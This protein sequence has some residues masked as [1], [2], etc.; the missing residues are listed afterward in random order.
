MQW[1]MKMKVFTFLIF[2][3]LLI[4]SVYALNVNF[5]NFYT[6]ASVTEMSPYF[7]GT[8]E[9]FNESHYV[10]IIDY[11]NYSMEEKADLTTSTI[12]KTTVSNAYPEGIPL[13]KE[14]SIQYKCEVYD[15]KTSTCTKYSTSKDF[16]TLTTKYAVIDNTWIPIPKIVG[17]WHIGNDS[18]IITITNQSVGVNNGTVSSYGV[19]NKPSVDGLI[20]YLNFEV[21]ANASTPITDLA[22][23]K[24]PNTTS[25]TSGNQI[26]QDSTCYSGKCWSQDGTDANQKGVE[27]TFS[28][29]NDLNFSKYSSFGVFTWIYPKSNTTEQAIFIIQSTFYLNVNKPTDGPGVNCEINDNNTASAGKLSLSKNTLHFVGCQYNGTH[30]ITYRDNESNAVAQNI[31]P[32]PGNQNPSIGTQGTT[33]YFN[34]S[35]DEVLIFNRSLSDSEISDLYLGNFSKGYVSGDFTEQ[36]INL[37]AVAQSE[38]DVINDT[39]TG[40]IPVGT[41]INISRRFYNW[42][43]FS[44]N[45]VLWAGMDDINNNTFSVYTTLGG[46]LRRTNSVYNITD[47]A[48]YCADN[49]CFRI[50]STSNNINAVDT[51]IGHNVTNSSWG[52]WIYIN[53]TDATDVG[54]MGSNTSNSINLFKVKYNPANKMSCEVNGTGYNNKG[55]FIQNSKVFLF[56]T[57]DGVNVTHYINGVKV[58]TAAAYPPQQLVTRINLGTEGYSSNEDY[59]AWHDNFMIFNRALTASEVL[60]L[61]N[62]MLRWNSYSSQCD[63]SVNS[64]GC[65]FGRQSNFTQA[66]LYMITNNGSLSPT[67][68]THLMTIQNVTSGGPIDS[69]PNV[70]FNYKIP[71]DII[72]LNSMGIRTNISYNITDDNGINASTV[73]LK[74]KTNNSVDDCDYYINGTS[75]C[76]YQSGSMSQY[77][78]SQVWNFIIGDNRL[79]PATYNYEPQTLEDTPPNSSLLSGSSSYLATELLNVSNNKPYG[80]YEIMSNGTGVQMVYYCNDSYNFASSPAGTSNCV[81]F[82]TIP[83]SQIYNHSHLL[84]SLHQVVPFGVNTTTG[85]IG[86]VKVS[87]KSYFMIRGNSNPA[88]SINYSFI[89]NASRVGASRT[90]STG[91]VSWV[92][93]T[94]TVDSHLHQFDNNTVFYYYACANDTINQQTCSSPIPDSMT[95]A[96]IPPNVII[97]NPTEALYSGFINITYDYFSANAYTMT[98]SNITLMN[99]SLNYNLTITANNSVNLSYNWN[100]SLARDGQYIIQVCA[101]DSQ[102]QPTCSYSENITINNSGNSCSCPSINANWVISMSDYCIITSNCFLGTGRLSFSNTGWA[103][104]K[105]TVNTTGMGSP[106]SN[107]VLYVNSTARINVKA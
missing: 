92:N 13:W 74:Y 68:Y 67:I 97:T 101:R 77:N 19:Q 10:F 39:I 33:V 99:T 71:A 21:D 35:I 85:S 12:T 3:I 61:N 49:K 80:F 26:V 104:I 63:L 84:Y 103:M 28:S 7:T 82:Y 91:G 16:N 83:A 41:Q 88:Q 100:S 52:L 56:C 17:T 58:G 69:P 86:S 11:K 105:A 54:F 20:R 89:N 42:S 75:Y 45:L 50:M 38:G 76:G 107:S 14:G 44:D 23:G 95:L 4:N 18:T 102:N 66:K 60:E 106:P 47:N 81:N 72:G 1:Y 36:V 31:L 48:S 57:Y 90:S 34:G 78:T 25:F 2:T 29:N 6:V 22:L 64:T 59:E 87:S 46:T 27:W 79:Y 5:Q 24:N 30:L 96:G 70:T 15:S 43:N 62:T 32:F 8:L 94:F 9:M 51:V 93:Q 40:S 53:T 65:L 73:Q 37:T 98:Y 55:N